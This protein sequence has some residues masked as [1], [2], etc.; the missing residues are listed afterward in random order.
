MLTTRFAATPDGLPG[1][2]DSGATS[3]W[4]VLSALGIYPVSPGDGI[5]QLTTPLFSRVTLRES[6]AEGA[7][8]PFVIEVQNAGP[9]SIYIQSVQLDGKPVDVPELRHA[10]IVRGG[11]LQLVGPQPSTWGTATP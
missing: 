11:T 6:A 3:A 9:D 1:N 7:T 8:G 10:D 4:Y 2:D 5:Y